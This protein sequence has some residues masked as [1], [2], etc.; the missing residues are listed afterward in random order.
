MAKASAKAYR[1]A[2]YRGRQVAGLLIVAGL[3]VSWGLLRANWHEVFPT[4]WWNVW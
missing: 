1:D 4:G 3:L 2:I